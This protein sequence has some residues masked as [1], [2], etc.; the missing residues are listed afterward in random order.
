MGA[1]AEFVEQWIDKLISICFIFELYSNTVRIFPE[2]YSC[3]GN[4]ISGRCDFLYSPRVS[5][6]TKRY[7]RECSYFIF[8]ILISGKK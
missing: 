3:D 2:T 5:V 8:A 4:K 6:S 7:H 1:T